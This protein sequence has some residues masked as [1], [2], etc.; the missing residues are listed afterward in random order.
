MESGRR[1]GDARRA[2]RGREAG[3]APGLMGCRFETLVEGPSVIVAARR[4]A[5]GP[6]T[7]Q[8]PQQ[9]A[10]EQW[11]RPGVRREGVKTLREARQ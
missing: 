9:R 6:V 4:D 7:T 1:L 3:F 5:E 8:A 2:R 11:R 10:E